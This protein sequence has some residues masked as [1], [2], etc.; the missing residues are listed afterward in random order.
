M[1]V[2][3]RGGN[4][5]VAPGDAAGQVAGNKIALICSG[6]PRALLRDVHDMVRVAGGK[7]DVNVP[8]AGQV[9][10]R[11]CVRL[12]G[13]PGGGEYLA[14]AVAGDP[15][16]AG[17]HH[18][19]GNRNPGL[20]GGL[21]SASTASIEGNARLGLRQDVRHFSSRDA[22]FAA[23]P[24]YGKHRT[25]IR[26]LLGFAD[27]GGTPGTLEARSAMVAIQDIHVFHSAW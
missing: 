9:S 23:I 21:R 20:T 11:R 4:L 7:L 1:G 10:G 24:V 19:G 17:L 27:L 16:L 13:S 8:A 2:R 18:V 22:Q 6:E 25:V 15:V 5:Y 12:S 3:Y 14:N 26:E